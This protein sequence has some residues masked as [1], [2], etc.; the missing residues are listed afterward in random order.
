MILEVIIIYPS[1]FVSGS[2]TP[3]MKEIWIFRMVYFLVEKSWIFSEKG[4]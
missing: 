3:I 1:D 4:S 2:K